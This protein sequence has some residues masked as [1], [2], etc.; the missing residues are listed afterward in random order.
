M[1]SAS[2]QLGSFAVAG[3]L[4]FVVDVGVLYGFVVVVGGAHAVAL[5]QYFAALRRPIRRRD[6]LRVVT[7]L[8]QTRQERFADISGANN[9][10]VCHGCHV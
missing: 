7:G 10:D 5:T 8:D 9:C 2:R 3:V 4:G 6:L 1:R